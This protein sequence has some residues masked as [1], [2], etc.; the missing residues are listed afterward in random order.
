MIVEHTVF[1]QKLD[2]QHLHLRQDFKVGPQVQR[3]R[4][5]GLLRH[6]QMVDA[7]NWGPGQKQS[8]SIAKERVRGIP[9]RYRNVSFPLPSLRIGEEQNNLA[10]MAAPQD[11]QVLADAFLPTALGFGLRDACNKDQ[12][13][14]K[15][16]LLEPDTIWG[17]PVSDDT[18]K[19]LPRD[20]GIRT[21]PIVKGVGQLTGEHRLARLDRLFFQKGDT[22]AGFFGQSGLLQV[23]DRQLG[24]V[25][26]SHQCQSSSIPEEKAPAQATHRYV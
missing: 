15:Q 16:E 1:L 3:H 11:A 20:I 18:F 7:I 12:L 6:L 9:T 25:D 4:A 2:V 21:I 10:V 26:C 22:V 8:L 14:C 19:E 5:A 24:V 17:R 23:R 13:G